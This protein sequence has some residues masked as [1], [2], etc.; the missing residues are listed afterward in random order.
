[1]EPSPRRLTPLREAPPDPLR[2]LAITLAA[3]H[4]VGARWQ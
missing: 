2:C 4:L 3:G 1:M